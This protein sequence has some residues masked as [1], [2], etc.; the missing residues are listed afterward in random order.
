MKIH[1][2]IYNNLQFLTSTR[3]SYRKGLQYKKL[4]V[5]LATS[6]SF[7]LKAEINKL[8]IGKT[9]YNIGKLSERKSIK[10]LNLS[11]LIT[12]IDVKISIPD[13]QF[14]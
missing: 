8:L 5:A 3:F 9:N 10:K 13:D 14:T 2:I 11:T 7:S 1:S 12:I 6:L 4:L